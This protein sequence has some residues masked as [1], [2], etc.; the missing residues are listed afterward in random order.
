[1]GAAGTGMG[2]AG[3]GA[4]GGAMSPQLMQMLM[5]MQGGG[6]AGTQPAPGPLQAQPTGTPM[7]NFIGQQGGQMHG[8][9]AGMPMGTPA[10]IQGLDQSAAA[11]G[12]GGMANPVNPQMMTMLQMLKNGQTGVPAQVGSGNPALSWNPNNP[13]GIETL[14][15]ATANN[16]WLQNL[17]ASLRGIGG[18]AV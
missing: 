15:G 18:S 2:A 1:M 6:Q 14:G 17:L 5:A 11:G 12:A 7:A 13:V 9:G 4:S 3:M 10:P 8:G 16:G